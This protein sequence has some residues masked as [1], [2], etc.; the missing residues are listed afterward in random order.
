MPKKSFEQFCQQ[1]PLPR[2]ELQSCLGLPILSTN[3]GE[4]LMML[5]RFAMLARFGPSALISSIN[6]VNK[7]LQ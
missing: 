3:K 2:H 5:A 4:T 1:G 6:Q 7:N